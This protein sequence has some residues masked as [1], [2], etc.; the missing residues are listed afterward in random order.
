[1]SVIEITGFS[2][3]YGDKKLFENTNFVLNKGEKIG[4]TG[5]NGAGKSTLLKII[6]GKVLLDRGDFYINPKFVIKYLDQHAEINQDITIKEYL[7]QAYQ[8]LYDTEEELTRVNHLLAEEKDAQKLEKL[9]E[10]S[11]DLFEYL[12]TN[13]FY[14]IDSNIEKIAAGLGV[15]AFGLDTKVKTLS[16]GQ[17]AKVI[18]AKL[19]LES[20]DVM[21]LDEPTNFLDV[22]H[23]DWLVKFIS[24]SEKSFIVVSHDYNFLNKISTHICDVDNNTITKYTGNV[25]QAFFIKDERLMQLEKSFEAQQREIK[26]LEDYISR[27]KARAST[28]RM[29]QSRV[30]RL[31]KMEIIDPPSEKIKP[32]FSFSEKGFVGNLMIKVE[33]LVVGYNNKPL[34]K[35]VNFELN[36]ADRLAI[37]G[38][39]GVGKSTLL[40]SIIGLIPSI[41]GIADIHRNVVYGYYEQENDFK[42]FSGTPV[43]YIQ[44]HFPKLNENQARTALS[45]CGLNSIHVKK[46]INQLSG[47]EQSKIKLCEISLSPSNVLILDEPTNHL[48]VLAIERLKEVMINYKGAIIFVSHDKNFV[49]EVA[50]KV[51]NLEEKIIKG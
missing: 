46:Q 51:Y 35:P 4:V 47:G 48:D 1:M 39:N 15:S 41:S 33:N 24:A 26:R 17:R 36:Y 34:L 27:N 20:P 11:G 30:K 21:I 40:K 49:A 13:D 31:E 28:A 29:A 16:G 44:N 18:L 23:I 37:A 38:F 6:T 22:S 14:S 7:Q 50:N 42:N 19:L 8:K 32:T 45:K 10:K 9:L 25:D 12:H 5:V 3:N 43:M 2:Q